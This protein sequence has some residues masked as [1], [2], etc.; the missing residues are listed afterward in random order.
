MVI[1]RLSKSDEFKQAIQAAGSK[2]VF[3]D[4]FATWCGPCRAIA[5]KYEEL[6]NTYS[7]ALFLKVDVDEL[8]DI[9]QEQGVSAMPT[10]MCFKDKQKKEEI[11]GG[12]VVIW[13]SDKC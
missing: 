3:V 2:A 11:R 12:S 9:A 4:F 6:S 1:Q 13:K 5:P 7:H 10:F 8:D